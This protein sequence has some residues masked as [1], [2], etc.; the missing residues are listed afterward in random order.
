MEF[1]KRNP[2]SSG[3]EALITVLADR[4]I[5]LRTYAWETLCSIAEEKLP[6]EQSAWWRWHAAQKYADENVLWDL[7]DTMPPGQQR[8]SMATR[9]P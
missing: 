8:P 3:N 4:N 9:Q 5:R 2:S 6:L 7:L 1:L